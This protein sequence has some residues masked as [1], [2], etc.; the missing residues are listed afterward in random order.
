MSLALLL[1]LATAAVWCLVFGVF[2][3]GQVILGLIF[4]SAFVLVTGA[5]RHRVVP[6]G[7]L[8]KRLFYAG[9]YLLLLIP[10]DIVRSN[11]DMARRII[12]PQPD[13]RPGIVRV[14]IGSVSQATSA[15]IA[16]AI[17]MS[18]GEMVIDYSPDGRTIYVHLVDVAEATAREAS[19]WRFYRLVLER[20]FP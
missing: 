15:L 5:G 9:V 19:F 3:L 16:H 4:G 12:R 18:P 10:Y 17:T 11:L 1:V 7:E 14:P 2:S 6:L 8:P 20:M 13:I